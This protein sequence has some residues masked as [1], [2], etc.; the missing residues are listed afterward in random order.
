MIN[1]ATS[2]S[3][4]SFLIFMASSST[5][6]FKNLRFETTKTTVVPFSPQ[7][8]REA[9]DREGKRAMPGR[10]QNSKHWFIPLPASPKFRGGDVVVSVAFIFTFL[11]LYL[12]RDVD[13]VDRVGKG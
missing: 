1:L 4:K 6:G 3:R 12:G 5:T 8:K 7:V 2:K 9:V 11:S 13:K 10:T